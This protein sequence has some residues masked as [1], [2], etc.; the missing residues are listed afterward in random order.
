MSFAGFCRSSINAFS[1]SDNTRAIQPPGSDS[2]T[3]TSSSSVPPSMSTC[4]TVRNQVSA[5][6]STDYKALVRPR[7]NVMLNGPR[8]TLE[9]LC[10]TLIVY[11]RPPEA[12]PQAKGPKKVIDRASSK[13]QDLCAG[14]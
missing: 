14:V 6:E 9:A 10:E 1:V 2:P 7:L 5:A 13:D 3:A 4:V 11:I 8:G 12:D